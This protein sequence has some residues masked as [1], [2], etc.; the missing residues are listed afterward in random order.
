MSE[1]KRRDQFNVL[2]N[3]LNSIVSSNNRKMDKS[4]VLKAAISNLKVYNG[5]FIHESKA[6]RLIG[7]YSPYLSLIK[8]LFYLSVI[9]ANL[10][11]LTADTHVK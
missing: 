8:N 2:I 6:V 11:T 7:G 1:K 5:K 4:T 10:A 3:E 9:L